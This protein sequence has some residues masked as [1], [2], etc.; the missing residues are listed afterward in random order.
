MEKQKHQYIHTLTPWCLHTIFCWTI[1]VLGAVLSYLFI[2]SKDGFL[3]EKE[4]Y[5]GME[6]FFICI[7]ELLLFSLAFD[8]IIKYE[9]KWEMED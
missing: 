7:T 9:N 6:Y 5:N 3:S 2:S 8:I 4:I 1:V